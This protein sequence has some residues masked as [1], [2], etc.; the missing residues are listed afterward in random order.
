MQ[1]LRLMAEILK[2]YTLHM[3]GELVLRSPLMGRIQEKMGQ[4]QELVFVLPAFPAKSPSPEKT[5][6]EN[7]DWAEVLALQGLQSLCERLTLLYAP[8]A[9]V[10]IC[11]DGRV[12]SDVVGVSDASIDRYGQ[13]ID[14][15]IREF[16]L[17]RLSTFNMEDL[18]P[19]LDPEELRAGPLQQFSRSVTEVRELVRS[20]DNHRRLF[21]GIHRFL[22]EDALVLNP[23]R[24]RSQLEKEMKERTYELLRRSDAWSE[25][26]KLR[27]ADDLRLSIHPYPPEH[28]KFGVKLVRSSERWATPWH[29]VAVKIGGRFELMHLKDA[30]KLRAR[31]KL[32]QEKYV[33]F[34]VAEVG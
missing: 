5:S 26:L 9:R 30:V 21:N 12:F 19:G 15:I 31:Q 16:S 10:V 18:F 2:E 13:G 28:E 7:P 20:Q 32:A 27:F 1:T 17:D 29:N 14:Q 4:G 34:E 11:S 3:S 33:Y 23:G 25:M 6:G 22:L 24:S 8:G